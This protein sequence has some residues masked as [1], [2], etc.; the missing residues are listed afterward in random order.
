VNHPRW[1]KWFTPQLP[2][3]HDKDLDSMILESRDAPNNQLYYIEVEAW[4]VPETDT[5]AEFELC[6][7]IME[8]YILDGKGMEIYNDYK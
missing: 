5:L 2:S 7:L 4:Q 1:Y 6:E 8:H 3:D